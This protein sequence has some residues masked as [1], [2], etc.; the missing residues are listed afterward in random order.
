MLPLGSVDDGINAVRA[1]LPL[2]TFDAG[3]CAEGIKVLKGYRKE[4]DED[5]SCFK[6]RPRHDWAS[7]GADGFRVLALGWRQVTSETVGPAS[8]WAPPRDINQAPPMIAVQDKVGDRARHGRGDAD[9]VRTA[10]AEAAQGRRL[11]TF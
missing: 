9:G 3:P 6:D 2:C 11:L 1:T 4:W 8:S 10:P 5:R 7:H